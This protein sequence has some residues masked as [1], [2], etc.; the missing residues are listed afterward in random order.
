[1]CTARPSM[2]WSSDVVWSH[3]SFAAISR[4]KRSRWN[5]VLRSACTFPF[6]STLLFIVVAF[7][8]FQWLYY[9][10]N[11]NNWVN[12][13]QSLSPFTALPRVRL[14][15]KYA[16]CTPWPSHLMPSGIYLLVCFVH[17][18]LVFKKKNLAGIETPDRNGQFYQHP[19]TLF[20]FFYESNII[21]KGLTFGLCYVIRLYNVHVSFCIVFQVV[22]MIITCYLRKIWTS[23]PW[24][25]CRGD[26]VWMTGL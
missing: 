8:V 14:G 15:V 13:Q 24:K 17:C 21:P 16:R 22:Q 5:C 18:F 4:S 2:K 9:E 19:L 7:H 20:A 26:P 6:S 10:H 1:M 3:L 11:F 23:E 12:F 25:P